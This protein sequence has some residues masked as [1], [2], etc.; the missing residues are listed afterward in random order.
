MNM[1][2][3]RDIVYNLLK[4]FLGRKTKI[5][6]VLTLEDTLRRTKG[7]CYTVKFKPE[8]LNAD[9]ICGLII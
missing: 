7:K 3:V 9:K 6:Y 2:P 4:T 8:K 5:K 1:N